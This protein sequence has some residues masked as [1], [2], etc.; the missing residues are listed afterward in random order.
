MTL[1]MNL[2]EIVSDNPNL[3]RHYKRDLTEHDRRVL[4][5]SKPG[6]RFVWILRQCGTA[7][8]PIGK[9]FDPIWA[10]YWLKGSSGCEKGTLPFYIEVTGQD[11]GCVLSLEHHEAG[12]LAREGYKYTVRE[13]R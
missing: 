5:D 12:E 6:D 10:T 7:L 11:E 8:F 2:L 3:L 9:G 1:Y 13:T 4:N